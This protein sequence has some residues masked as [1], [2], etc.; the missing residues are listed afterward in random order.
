M[1]SYTAPLLIGSKVFNN[2][3]DIHYQ[4]N[5]IATASTWYHRQFE[6]TNEAFLTKIKGNHTNSLIYN[7]LSIHV[8]DVINVYLVNKNYMLNGG[9]HTKT[10]LMITLNFNILDKLYSLNINDLQFKHLI[11]I[12]EN[13]NNAKTRMLYMID[14]SANNEY[15]KFNLLCYEKNIY[16]FLKRQLWLDDKFIDIKIFDLYSNDVTSKIKEIIKNETTDNPV[17]NDVILIPTTP[18][19]KRKFKN[20]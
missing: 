7:Q 10:H 13:M 15:L 20:K 8:N 17:N 6:K 11:N 9:C 1:E 2:S 18:T 16:K 4:I 19:K 12:E 5:Y 3:S 14:I